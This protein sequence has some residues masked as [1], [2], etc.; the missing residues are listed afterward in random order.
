[1]LPLPD[2]RN[3]VGMPDPIALVTDAEQ[4]QQI[5]ALL[6]S[7][8]RK[9]TNRVEREPDAVETVE[10]ADQASALALELLQRRTQ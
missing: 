3:I 8:R 6:D 4:L 1:M 7:I 5:A 10:L 9:A 2:S